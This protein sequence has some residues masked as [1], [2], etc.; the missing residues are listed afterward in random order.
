MKYNQLAN[1]VAR[2]VERLG[3]DELDAITEDQR[4]VLVWRVLQFVEL[5]FNSDVSITLAYAGADLGCARELLAKGCP[6]RTA[7]RILL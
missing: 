1:V 3:Y 5:G 4:R 7:A 6:L 2:E